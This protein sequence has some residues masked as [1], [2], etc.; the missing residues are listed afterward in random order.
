TREQLYERIR[1]SSKQEV[2][3]EEMQRRIGYGRER[4]WGHGRCAP[5]GPMHWKKKMRTGRES[6]RRA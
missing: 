6:R 3:L 4:G 5:H 1:G 2:V